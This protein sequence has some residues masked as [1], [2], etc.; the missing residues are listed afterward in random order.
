M[1]KFHC[2]LFTVSNHKFA[3]PLD[4]VERV[5]R[6]VEVTPLPD[7]PETVAG[8]I[9]VHGR[10]VP[11]VDMRRRLQPSPYLQ[12]LPAAPGRS[13][14]ERSLP[15]LEL[16]D[17]LIIARSGDDMV[18][19]VA[20]SVEGVATYNSNDIVISEAPPGG[21]VA[22][23]RLH[24]LLATGDDIILVRHPAHF[25]LAE[26]QARFAGVLEPGTLE[27]GA[28]ESSALESSALESSALESSAPR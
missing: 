2:V 12:A 26:E 1:S 25:L 21:N 3:L 27:S 20:N 4:C 11:V 28:L 16:S 13:L 24:G 6:A 10:L 7:M 9:N 8:V 5:V 15:E 22:D 19:I 23:G 17:Q 18:A 14:P